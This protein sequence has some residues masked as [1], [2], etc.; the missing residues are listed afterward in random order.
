[1]LIVFVV[2]YCFITI[3]KKKTPDSTAIFFMFC[4][5]IFVGYFYHTNSQSIT[6]LL[7]WSFYLV[8]GHG[9]TYFL[10]CDIGQNK[11]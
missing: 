8:F 10:L 11:N 9:F 4:L 2:V 7:R 5:V 1:M 6:I 3:E